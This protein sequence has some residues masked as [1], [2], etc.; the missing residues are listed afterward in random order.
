MVLNKLPAKRQRSCRSGVDFKDARDPVC[1]SWHRGRLV[2]EQKWDPN[3]VLMMP[4]IRSGSQR[5]RPIVVI[6]TN[7]EAGK[8][9]VPDEAG[10]RELLPPVCQILGQWEHQERLIR[11][12]GIAK[13][14][15]SHPGEGYRDDMAAAVLDRSGSVS[16]EP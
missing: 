6:K 5:Q 13:A 8:Q 12:L 11:D 14:Q 3:P 9:F 10:D 16:L 1:D 7:Q 4:K 15:R 2:S